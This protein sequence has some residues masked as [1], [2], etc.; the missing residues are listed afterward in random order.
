MLLAVL[1]R[2]AVLLSYASSLTHTMML[3]FE[4]P[5]SAS[6]AALRQD[7][8]KVAAEGEHTW[9]CATMHISYLLIAWRLVELS[10]GSAHPHPFPK[11]TANIVPSTI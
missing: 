7:K 11:A 3:A 4:V 6:A 1:N 5:A 2:W 10:A 8:L 9:G